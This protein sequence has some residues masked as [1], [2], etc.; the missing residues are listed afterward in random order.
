MILSESCSRLT[1]AASSNGG[2][3]YPDGQTRTR[4]GKEQTL[5]A[6]STWAGTTAKTLSLTVAS[7]DLRV[8]TVKTVE[9]RKLLRCFVVS[10]DGLE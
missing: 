10:E 1:V 7:T 6:K 9:M 4:E 3:N 5:N 8:A 2:D